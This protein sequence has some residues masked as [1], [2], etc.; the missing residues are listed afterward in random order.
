MTFKPS[1]GQ[2]ARGDNFFPRPRITIEI[3]QKLDSGSNLLLVAPR[4]VGKSSIL[5][6]LLDVTRENNI[7][8]Y[9]VSESVNNENEFY[10]K[11]FN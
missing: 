1:I 9:Y 6:N 3:W 10:H 5:F 7:V 2:V 4:R 11:L 8:I